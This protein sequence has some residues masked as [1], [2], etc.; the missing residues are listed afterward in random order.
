MQAEIKATVNSYS[1]FR[2]TWNSGETKY[3]KE[4]AP[5]TMTLLVRPNLKTYLCIEHGIYI[6]FFINSVCVYGGDA[7]K[8]TLKMMTFISMY[9]KRLQVR[10]IFPLETDLSDINP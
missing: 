4:A 3:Y 5:R 6:P 10:Q 7:H 2:G 1:E 9:L 8:M